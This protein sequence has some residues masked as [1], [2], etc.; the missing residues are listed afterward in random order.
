MSASGFGRRGEVFEGKEI[1]HAKIQGV[2]GQGASGSRGYMG[3]GEQ[4]FRRP[5]VQRSWGQSEELAF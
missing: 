1:P 2:T 5:G 4:G 3:E